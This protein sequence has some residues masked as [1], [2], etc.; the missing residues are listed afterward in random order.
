MNNKTDIKKILAVATAGLM[1]FTAGCSNG[2]KPDIIGMVKDFVMGNDKEDDGS[3]YLFRCSI[4][5]K[6]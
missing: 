3:G 4:E 6:P 5:G 2:E 1:I